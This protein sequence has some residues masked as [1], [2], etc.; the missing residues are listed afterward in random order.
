MQQPRWTALAL[1]LACA[2]CETA[3]NTDAGA[4]RDA[5]SDAPSSA[6]D[7][8][9]QDSAIDADASTQDSAALEVPTWHEHVRPIVNARCASCHRE[10][11]VGPFALDSLGQMRA[12]ANAS[13]AAVEARRMPPWMPAQGCA[14]FAQDRSMTEGEIETLRRWVRGAMPEGDPARAPAMMPV[15]NVSF[16]ADLRLPMPGDYT[17]DFSRSATNADDYHCFVLSRGVDRTLWITG[18]D[19]EPGVRAMVHHANVHAIPAASAAMLPAGPQGYSCFGGAGLSGSRT[20][21]VWVPGTP[22]TKFPANT[23]IE[24]QAGEALVV[25]MHYY[26]FMPGGAPPADRS[27]MLFELTPVRPPRFAQMVGP[28]GPGNFSIPART[29]GHVI[30]GSWTV[31][32]RGTLWGV[33][34]HMHKIGRRITVRVGDACAVDIPAWNFH[35]QQLYFYRQMGGIPVNAGLLTSIACEYD[36]PGSATVSNGEGS[37]EEMCGAPFFFTPE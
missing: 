36:N 37:D 12:F 16:R 20:V 32:S 15:E 25:Q 30:S 14:Q 27:T 18:Y 24:V 23:A 8:L 22:P 11:Q 3:L 21:S 6:P 28:G 31:P 9:L 34:P 26:R 13:L 4:P 35:W 2:R 29:S 19:L 10:G 33:L 17:P 7:V 5:A 1:A